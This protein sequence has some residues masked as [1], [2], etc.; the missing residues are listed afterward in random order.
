MNIDMAALHAIEVDRGIPVDELL[1]TIKSALLTAYRHTEGHEPDARIEIDR[2]TGAVQVIARQTDADG[3]VIHEWDDTPEGFGRIAATTARQVMLQRFRD[4][5][6][7][8]I[9]GEFS[10][11]EGDIVAGVVQRDARENARGNVVVRLGTETK[12]SDGTIR[13]AEQV[14]GES[15]QHGDRLRCYVIGVTR[16]LREPRIELSRTHP[17]LVR[18][19]FALEVPEIA[20]GSVEIVAVAREAG[21]RSKIAVRSKVPG[22][23]AKGA[24]IGPM[25]QRVRNVMSE[26]SGEKIDIIDWDEDPAKFVANALSPAKVVSVSIIDEAAR[27]AR[28]V[29]PDFQL[30][31]AIGKEGQN[32]R[33][34]ARLT[35]WRIDI[36][37]DAAP[38]DTPEPNPGAARGAVHES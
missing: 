27:A 4:A 29:V 18:K 20:E 21:H 25:G 10:A 12:G 16:G 32:A 22:L 36:R 8:R 33:L 6:N 31:L 13:P 2:R 3:N 14:P 37:S 34:A 28:V 5:E 15:Y 23:N 7:E 35:G 26:L 30:S 17:N 24:C 1:E 9:Y 19:L 38:G 11:R